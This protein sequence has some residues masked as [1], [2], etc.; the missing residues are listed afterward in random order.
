MDNK[1]A[2]RGVGEVLLWEVNLLGSL[3]DLVADVGLDADN[4]C[5]GK[6]ARKR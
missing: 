6:D 1:V 4:P 3:I 2:L 5:L